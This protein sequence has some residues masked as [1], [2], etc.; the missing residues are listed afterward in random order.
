MENLIQALN[1]YH[2]VLFLAI[3]AGLVSHQGFRKYEPTISSFL[4]VFFSLQAITF[5]Q[6]VVRNGSSLESL[7]S[8][9]LLTA[10]FGVIYLG[11]LGISIVLYRVYFHPLRH[12]PGPKL[13]RITKI[14]WFFRKRDGQ[15]YLLHKKVKFN[16]KALAVPDYSDSSSM[17]M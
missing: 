12:Y 8:S 2:E 5:L 11:V 14:E 15:F 9:A 17:A 1:P 4:G 7:V 6:I 13:S 3:V 16:P 10:M